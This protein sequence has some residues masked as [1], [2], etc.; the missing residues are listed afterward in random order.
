MKNKL[1]VFLLLT[2]VFFTSCTVHKTITKPSPHLELKTTTTK[3][4]LKINNKWWENF[5]DKDLN[6]VVEKVLQKNLTLEQSVAKLKQMEAV[7]GIAKA[8]L[9]PFVNLDINGKSTKYSYNT[10][11]M[12]DATQTDKIEL[13]TVTATVG[14]QVDLWKKVIN[15]KKA[16]IY[17]YLASEKAA[18][19]V[20]MTVVSTTVD[21]YYSICEQEKAVKLIE[22]QIEVLNNYLNLVSSRAEKGLASLL[23]VLQQKQL[24]ESTKNLL[25]LEQLKLGVLKNQLAV[26]LSQDP[27][28]FTISHSDCSIPQPDDLPQK[29][30][31]AQLLLN[32]PDVKAA[33]LS[34]I[35]ADHQLAVAIA[36]RFPNITISANFGSQMDSPSTLFDRWFL[37]LSGD[38]LTPLFDGSRRKNE[39]KRNKAVV[40]EKFKAWQYSIL[41]AIKEIQDAIITEQKNKEVLNLTKNQV[42]LAKETLTQSLNRYKSGLTDYLSVL[43]AQKTYY[44]LQRD[45]LR[46]QRELVSNRVKLY[47]SLGGDFSNYINNKNIN[48]ELEERK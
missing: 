43:S 19:A 4:Q 44:T 31:S 42:I 23:E 27:K 20:A 35:A 17:N 18:E 5:N 11:N 41:N 14:Y 3:N 46:K 26:L 38:I 32:R 16:A 25:P 33:E 2:T 24:L 48:I 6:K 21:L 47:L 8:G 29:G 40:Y 34:L 45:M 1:F 9:M 39:V 15:G 30:I 10:F 37:S 13:Y 36:D 28:S 7:A 12:F 22:N